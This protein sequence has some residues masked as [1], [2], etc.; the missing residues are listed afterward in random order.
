VPSYSTVRGNPTATGAAQP[1]FPDPTATLTLK[2]GNPD[3]FAVDVGV[4]VRKIPFDGK[5]SRPW[6]W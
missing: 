3:R 4:D 5:A 6:P 1:D 2:I